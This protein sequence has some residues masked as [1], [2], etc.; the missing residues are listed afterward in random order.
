M[1]RDTE[2]D[3]KE[4]LKTLQQDPIER[5]Q[6]LQ[7]FLGLLNSIN[8]NS[9]LT[10]DGSWG[11][12]KTIFVKQ[13]HY[14]NTCDTS[15]VQSLNAGV[16][17]KFQADYITYFYN[18]WENDYHEDPLQSLLFNLINDFWEKREKTADKTA[19][20]TK[21]FLNS[22]V[23]A[24]SLR[25]IDPEEIRKAPSISDLVKSI[26]TVSERKDAIDDIIDNRLNREGKKI[27][28][29]ID[30]LDRCKPTFAVKLLE[31]LKHYCTNGRL[32]FLLSTNNQQLS[33]TIKKV[34]GENFDGA[35]YLNKFYDLIFDLPPADTEK[36]I[37]YLGKNSASLHWKDITPAEV[38]DY[39]DLSMREI[40]RYYSSLELI[41]KY[42]ASINHFSSTS[43]DLVKYFF[44]PLAYGLRIHDPTSYNKFVTG[45]GVDIIRGF[46]K[47]ADS[48][49]RFIKS[50]DNLDDTQDPITAIEKIYS[51]LFTVNSRDDRD[52]YHI[53]ESANTFKQVITL[54]NASG[55]ID[56]D[57]AEAIQQ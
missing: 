5:N 54:M 6:Q 29:I 22:V 20:V 38:V 27:L 2:F 1:I 55:T 7:T 24:T 12:G 10:I 36:Y 52:S 48:P 46:C 44:V 28:F 9:F 4:L 37:K 57:S 26:T 14:L 35:G 40:N 19:K 34:Y 3:D 16:L 39:L 11:S 32:V 51:K 13:I 23:K 45:S 41:K 42:L 15:R 30:E 8:K 43:D 33:H 17:Q 25:L 50:K 31:V 21:G 18:A 49:S 53:I 47:K 56:D